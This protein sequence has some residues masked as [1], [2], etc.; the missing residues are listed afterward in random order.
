MTLLEFLGAF[1]FVGT[2]GGAT[3]RAWKARHDPMRGPDA[4]SPAPPYATAAAAC[5]L[6]LRKT[7]G[8]SE[9]RTLE[10]LSGDLW[11]RLEQRARGRDENDSRQFETRVTVTRAKGLVPITL[12]RERHGLFE[13]DLSAREIEIGDKSF[14]DDFEV[15]GPHTFVRAL[16][17]G[18]TRRL[19]QALLLEM[20]L[21]LD[22]GQLY[23]ALPMTTSWELHEHALA[24]MLSLMLDV[25]RRLER[26]R[27][28]V[29][30]LADNARLD[31]SPEDRLQNLLTLVREFPEQPVTDDALVAAC[32]DASDWIRVR[33]AT[34]LGERGRA[35]L[36]EVAGRDP[37]DDVASAQAIVVLG[38]RLAPERVSEI[39]GRALRS[40]QPGMVRACLAALGQGGGGEAVGLMAKVMGVE[41]GELAIAAADALAQTA[42][43]DAEAHLIAALTRDIPE[44][45]IAAARGL[46]R[47]GSAAAILPLKEAE[48]RHAGESGFSRAAR[49]AIAQIQERLTGASPGQLSLTTAEAGMLSLTEDER[50]RLSLKDPERR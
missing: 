27:D 38:K 32:T 14:D 20:D 9:R 48:A 23:G 15:N 43:P 31:P 49:Q 46:G 22:R 36:L 29:Q 1:V 42:S 19:L 11:V 33:A 41:K 7:G 13:R 50:G 16:L 8:R 45:R 2:V 39:L 26:P 6:T 28:L 3:W 24:R 30:R 18:P 4:Q 25:G 17:D 40:R 12:R 44:L 21:E 5:G 37:P 10:G 47:V 34:A 35:T